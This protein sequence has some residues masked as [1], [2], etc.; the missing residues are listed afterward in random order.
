MHKRA[1]ECLHV[2]NKRNFPQATCK[3]NSKINV[4]FRL[5][6]HGELYFLSHNNSVHIILF[7]LEKLKKNYWTE[8]ENIGKNI[9]QNHY[10]G[11]QI[12]TTKTTTISTLY[13]HIVSKRPYHHNFYFPIWC[14][15]SC[16]EVLRKK[17]L[18]WIKSDFL[19]TF[20][21]LEILFSFG[22]TRDADH[23]IDMLRFVT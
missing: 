19:W 17:F 5:N 2:H 20:K 4:P 23:S 3:L 18:I 9:Q 7:N 11:M 15:I 1:N 22:S 6:E 21:N 8:K 16:N 13:V 14:Y 10:S 12:M